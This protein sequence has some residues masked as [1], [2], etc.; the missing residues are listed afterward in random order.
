MASPDQ[1]F[2]AAPRPAATSDCQRPDHVVALAMPMWVES[3]SA[4]AG[5][6]GPI[7]GYAIAIGWNAP[8]KSTAYLISDDARPRPVWVSEADLSA[9]SVRRPS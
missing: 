2:Q 1:Q 9:N 7:T 6:G 4:E 5:D 8:Q 3:E